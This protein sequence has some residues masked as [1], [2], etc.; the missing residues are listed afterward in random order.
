[1]EGRK[2]VYFKILHNRDL[3]RCS[4]SFN[5]LNVVTAMPDTYGIRFFGMMSWKNPFCKEPFSKRLIST[6]GSLK[7]P[8]SASKNHQQMVP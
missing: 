8:K 5:S 6:T 4:L 3:E 1:M 7:N 2:D